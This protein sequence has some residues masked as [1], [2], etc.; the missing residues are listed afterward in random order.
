MEVQVQMFNNFIE[1][2]YKGPSVQQIQAKYRTHP[3]YYFAYGSNLNK[4]Q[5]S[6]RCPTAQFIGAAEL[7]GFKLVFRGVLDIEHAHANSKVSGAIFKVK[8][9]ISLHVLKY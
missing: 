7:T 1:Y 4:K 6:V 9:R 2:K 3:R 8:S 5:M